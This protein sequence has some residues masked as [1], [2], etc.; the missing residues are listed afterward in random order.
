MGNLTHKAEY[1]NFRRIKKYKKD[2]IIISAKRVG[3]YIK[4]SSRDSGQSIIKHE[5]IKVE[6]DEGDTYVIHHEGYGKD[7]KTVSPSVLRGE[8]YEEQPI[9]V[10][11]Y[12]TIGEAEK[13]GGKGRGYFG[14]KTCIGMANRIQECL[15]GF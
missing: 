8:G 6:T 2:Q 11:K 3:R 5:W 13:I 12:I 15:E 1:N 4:G 7:I 10:R 9:K 14:N